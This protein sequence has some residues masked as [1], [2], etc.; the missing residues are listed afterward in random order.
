M[1][2]IRKGGLRP[3]DLAKGSRDTSSAPMGVKE[4]TARHR[5]WA[6]HDDNSR[7]NTT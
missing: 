6:I 3:N 1:S 4:L 7:P 5:S 2:L